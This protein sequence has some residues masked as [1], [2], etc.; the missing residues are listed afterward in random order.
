MT[1]AHHPDDALLL[2]YAA[3]ATDEATSLILA[4][5]LALCPRCRR[6]V[7]QAEAAGGVLLSKGKPT[8]LREDALQLALSRLDEEPAARPRPRTMSLGASSL[9]EPLRSY[10]GADLAD[11]D[12]TSIGF[13]ISFKPL[14]KR[15]PSN[16]QLI[17]SKAGR[18]VG[19]HS[20]GGEEL[21]LVLTGGFTDVTGHYRRGDLQSTTPDILHRPLADSG[22]DCVVL[23][24][25]DA[26]L[27][28]SNLGVALLGKLFGF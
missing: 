24:V 1:I 11:V 20:H 13:G 28:F 4:A 9:P 21:T 27:R 15:G 18:G 2:G 17:R 19:A 26:S 22:E 8:A 14:L 12:W 23:A 25:T 5:H 3:G 10:I 7:S 6:V 16:V